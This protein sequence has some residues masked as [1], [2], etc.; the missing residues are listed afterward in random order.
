METRLYQLHVSV[1]L[2][3]VDSLG[4][5]R[6]NMDFLLSLPGFGYLGVRWIWHIE[7]AHACKILFNWVMLM[8]AAK[9]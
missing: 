5:G 7:H 6:G 9:I 4:H 3:Y 2:Y 1:M 8:S